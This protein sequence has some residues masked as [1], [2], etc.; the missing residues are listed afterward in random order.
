MQPLGS[1]ALANEKPRLCFRA[2]AAPV[3]RAARESWTP[4]G[5]QM[6][7][8]ERIRPNW[9]GVS[10]CLAFIS[11]EASRV[12]RFMKQIMKINEKCF[13]PF[14]VMLWLAASSPLL[15]ADAP[16]TFKVGEFNFQRPAQWEWVVPNSPM[17]KAELKVNDAKGKA[18]VIFF[19]FGGGQGGGTKANIDRWLGMFQEPRDQINAKTE[20][21]A[22]GKRKITYVQAQGTYMSGMPGGPKTPLKNHALLGAIVESDDGNVFARMT[23]PGEVVKSAEADFKKMIESGMK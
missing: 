15:S 10:F 16:A 13:L 14:G 5:S 3:N 17:R 20:E 1:S 23:G 8:A 9:P 21:K 11:Y 2:L 19:N 4:P 12:V 6:K 22:I 7:A 18:E